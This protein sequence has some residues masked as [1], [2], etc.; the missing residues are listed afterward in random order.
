MKTYSFQEFMSV[1]S[2]VPENLFSE[3]FFNTGSLIMVGVGA[4]AI[5]GVILE[6]QLVKRDDEESAQSVAMFFTI[7]FTGAGIGGSLWLLNY[8]L[9]SL[10]FMF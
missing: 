5:G 6:T 3:M 4:V 8:A 9:K 7:L 10:K 1:S 2:I